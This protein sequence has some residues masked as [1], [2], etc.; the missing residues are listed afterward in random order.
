MTN[1]PA[2]EA[3]TGRAGRAGRGSAPPGSPR[4]IT[5]QQAADLLGVKPETVYAYVSRGV[6]ARHRGPDRRS[7]RFDRIEVERLAKRNRRGGRAGA[8]EVV[9]DTE[10]TLLDPEGA[11][12]YRGRDAVELA[13]TRRFE[14]VAELLWGT[15]DGETWRAPTSSVRVG[16]RAQNALPASA[17]VA[18]RMRV[19]VASLAACDPM[20]DDRR[21]AAVAAAARTLIAGTVA[22]LPELSPP[23]GNSVAERLWSRLCDRPPKR[24]ETKALDAALILLADHELAASTL[25]ARIAASVWADPYLVVLTGLAAG[26]GV[27]HAASSSRVEAFLREATAGSADVSRLVGDRLRQGEPLP[28]FGHAVY[29]GRDPRADALLDLVRRAGAKGAVDVAAEEVLGVAGRHGGPAPSIDFA[30]GVLAVKAGWPR[31]R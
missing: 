6:L 3:A 31:V 11:L 12:Y 17:R 10:L 20:R 26:G 15:S 19:V 8:L 1:T 16:R 9:I 18:D 22:C 4:W 27:L 7:S 24:G 2:D 28:G 14:Q 29:T 30:L 21:P 25:A 5:T 13:R 23:S